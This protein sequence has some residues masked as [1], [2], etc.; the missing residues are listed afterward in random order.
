M[1]LDETKEILNFLKTN[2]PQSFR[3]MSS[4]ERQ[5]FLMLW[6]EAFEKMPFELVRKAV[7]SITLES[8]REF[9]PNVGQ[10]NAR[11]KAL[12][13][14]NTEEE[15]SDAWE[16]VRSFIRDYHPEDYRKKYEVLPERVRKILSCTDIREIGMADQTQLGYIHSRFLKS[17]AS[18]K[19]SEEA[20][21]ITKGTLIGMADTEKLAEIGIAKRD[22]LP[23]DYNANP[24]RGELAT[25]LKPEEAA[26]MQ[27]KLKRMAK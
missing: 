14:P 15:A 12:V 8:E 27:N 20:V 23:E 5:A 16:R 10:V 4:E 22:A 26:E 18:V 1:T 24:V 7:I 13:L 2:Y 11:I 6:S 21:A 17:Y 19:E 25:P 9:A 3:A